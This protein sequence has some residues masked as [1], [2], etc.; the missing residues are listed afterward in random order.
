MSY[1]NHL[2][3]LFIKYVYLFQNQVAA[4]Q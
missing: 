4:L 3:H 2:M 1:I